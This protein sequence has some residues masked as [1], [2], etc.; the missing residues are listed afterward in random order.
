MHF[1]ILFLQEILPGLAGDPNSI[2]VSLLFQ[3]GFQ[4]PENF[5]HVK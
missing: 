5:I 1:M 4:F 2:L 3:P